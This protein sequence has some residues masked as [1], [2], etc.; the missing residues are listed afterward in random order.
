MA[1]LLCRVDGGR[2]GRV[3]LGLCLEGCHRHGRD[4]TGFRFASDEYCAMVPES[5]QGKI[6]V[7]SGSF[8]PVHIGHLALANWLCEFAGLDEVWFVV[9]PHNP[10]KERA[11]LMDDRLRLE[12]VEKAVAG[13]PKFRACDVEFRL[14]KPSFTVST[15]KVLKRSFPSAS[16]SLIIGGDNWEKFDRWKDY[17]EILSACEVFVYPRKGSRCAVDAGRFPGV[18][19]VDAPEMEISST[20]IRKALREGKDV[21]FFVPEPVRGLLAEVFAK[22]TDG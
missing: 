12:M 5:F 4:G 10:F 6:G 19:I 18:H 14:P 1:L 11:D 16:F 13:Y 2:V 7:Y 22:K 21:R 20:F 3:C 15:L 8:N 9:T 17:R